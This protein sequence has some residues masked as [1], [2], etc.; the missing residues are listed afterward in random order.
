M[1]VINPARIVSRQSWGARPPT[2]VDTVFTKDGGVVVHY[3]TRNADTL[4]SHWPDCYNSW[5][6]HQAYHMDSKKW[7]DLAY[8]FGLCPHGFL[9]VGRGWDAQNGANTPL[10]TSTLSVCVDFDSDDQ[11]I[12]SVIMALNELIAEAVTERGWAP[13]VRGHGQASGTGTPCP[14][15]ILQALIANGTIKVPTIQIPPAVPSPPVSPPAPSVQTPSTPILGSASTITVPR[16]QA[17]AVRRG[18]TPRFV[19]LAYFA[20][21][22]GLKTGVD[23]AVVYGIMAHESGFGQFGGVLDATFHNW[24]GIKT[25]AGGDNF[26]PAAHARFESDEVGVRAVAQHAALYAGVV[27]PSEVVV[28]PRHFDSIR[29]KASTLESPGWTWASSSHGPRVAAYTREMRG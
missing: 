13:I 14:G 1:S 19:Q 27:L 29:G 2:G 6:N 8:N 22:E 26:D 10:N 16:M 9:F 17:W 18:A 21:L 15:P 25:A 4:K 11:P 20:W 3:S 7:N 24:G 12:E 5:R 28:D 23:P